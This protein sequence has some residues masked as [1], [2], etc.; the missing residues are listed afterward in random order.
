MPQFFYAVPCQAEP[1]LP[2]IPNTIIRNGH[3]SVFDI[4]TD[5]DLGV[6]AH[7]KASCICNG[8]SKSF[9]PYTNY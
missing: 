8:R 1:I 4:L 3:W 5:I 7:E 9:I 2:S 6:P